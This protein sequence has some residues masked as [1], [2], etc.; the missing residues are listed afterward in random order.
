MALK[1]WRGVEVTRLSAC[2]G[3]GLL[4][5][6]VV[7]KASSNMMGYETVVCYV[8]LTVTGLKRRWLR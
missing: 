6:L 7:S 3:G 1:F 8:V 2:Y 4:P 5:S